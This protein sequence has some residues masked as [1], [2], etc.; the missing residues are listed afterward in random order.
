M[1]FENV[2]VDE[3]RR[4]LQNCLDTINY[5]STTSIINSLDSNSIWEAKA[6][7]NLKTSLQTLKDNRYQDLKNK[8]EEYMKL[9]DD[10]SSY[11]GNSS[12]VQSLLQEKAIAE[13]NLRIEQNKSKPNQSV[14]NNLKN[15]LNNVN[16]QLDDYNNRMNSIKNSISNSI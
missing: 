16:M 12:A 2:N 6:K 10:I 4:S 1:A 11:K 15:H 3:L 9:V 14:I 5:D 7:S 8:L 13:R